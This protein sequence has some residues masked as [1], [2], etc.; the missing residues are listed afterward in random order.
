MRSAFTSSI[1]R[2]ACGS[3]ALLLVLLSSAPSAAASS[4]PGGLI[5]SALAGRPKPSFLAKIRAGEMG[6][7]ILVGSWT[8]GE[9]AA[10]T[11]QLHAAGCAIGRPLLLMVDQ[12]G[13]YA[14]R[15]TWAPP[16]H[17]AGE[18]GRLG[19]AETRAEATGA[20]R[21]LRRLGIDIDLA[22]V[23]DTLAPGGFLKSRSFGSD[24][25]LVGRLAATFVHGLQAQRIAAT[26]KHFPGLGTARR[27][28]DDYEVSLAATELAPFRTAI[29]AQPKLV[30]VSNASY[31]AL[32]GTGS[33]A[34]FSRP[35]VTGL[36]RGSFGFGGVVVSDAL[37]APVPYKV[38]HAP[39]RALAAGVDL[40]LYTSGST[41]HAASVQLAEDA[42]SSA[43]VRANVARASARLAALR[44]WLRRSC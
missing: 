2:A 7:V 34:V 9:M 26:V 27:S 38:A 1:R 43:A 8:P 13:G 23:T 31:P 15:L 14:R 41:A 3:S 16:Q 44:R 24:A 37:D 4:Q 39:A 17:T 11:R 35:I 30:M 6:G 40:L 18:L 29:A 22:P 21:A 33:A 20:A 19:A 28:T 32:D 42:R 25:D 36:L 12:E 10:T 5:V